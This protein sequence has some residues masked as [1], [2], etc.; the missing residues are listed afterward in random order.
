MASE[1]APGKTKTS[2]SIEINGQR[3]P[4]TPEGIK[5]AQAEHGKVGEKIVEAVRQA[6]ER[7]IEGG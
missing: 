1:A 3:V 2:M 6:V 5:R 7:A 4:L